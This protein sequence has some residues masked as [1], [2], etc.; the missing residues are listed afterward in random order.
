MARRPRLFGEKLYH[1]IYAWGNNR[2]AIFIDNQHYARYLDLLEKFSRDY[3]LDI[4]AYALMQT[5]VHLFAYDLK[6]R[7]SEFMNSLHGEYAQY[8]NRVTGRVGHVFGER[9]NNKV[10]QPNVYAQWLSRYIHRQAVEAGLVTDPR[11]YPW[12][13]YGAYLSEVPLGFVKPRVI[14]E[15]FGT[16][17]ESIRNYVEFVLGIDRGPIDWDMKSTIVVGDENYRKDVRERKP[18]IDQENPSDKEILDLVTARFEV[19]TRLLIAPRGR[20]EK[21]YRR[22]LVRYLVDEVGLKP[23]RIMRLCHVSRSAVQR[24]LDAKVQKYMPVPKEG[25]E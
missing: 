10:V 3:R 9:F 19:N 16:G 21:R 2:Q 23:A 18:A 17:Q 22:K 14:L 25:E 11:D 8:F 12:S 24:A 1:H 20:E 4:I 6:G 15:Q 13:S 5:H 7:V